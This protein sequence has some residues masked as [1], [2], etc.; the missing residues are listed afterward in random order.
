MDSTQLI[1]SSS[2]G[3]FQ[4][5]SLWLPFDTKEEKVLITVRSK[6]N[7]SVL[8]TKIIFIKKKEDDETLRSVND[9][10]N[11][12]PAKKRKRSK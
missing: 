4:G 3:K 1:F 11:D 12:P 5:N 10:L 7:P 6:Q 8:I 2:Y 9:I